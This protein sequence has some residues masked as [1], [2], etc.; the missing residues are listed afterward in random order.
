MIVPNY[1]VVVPSIYVGA[2]LGYLG[3]AS[4]FS[5]YGD[6]GKALLALNV[7]LFRLLR[8]L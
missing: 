4:L 1:A 6:A 3:A 5:K 7:E 8:Q 2:S